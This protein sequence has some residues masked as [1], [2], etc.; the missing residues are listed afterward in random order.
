VI[1]VRHAEK[2][3]ASAMMQS[4]DMELSEEGRARAERFRDLVWKYRP[5]AVY[6]TPFKRTR[7]TAE[8]IARLRGLEIETYDPAK[9]AEL[10]EKILTGKRKRIVVVGHSNTIPELANLLARKEL[11]R[12]LA[13]AE[14]GVYYVIRL[15][16]G[17]LKR[18]EIFPF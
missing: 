8:P 1:L 3:A 9:Q 2:V 11:F 4:P 5:G 12:N 17:V 10:V 15:E 18:I 6:S 16:R 14:Y 7:Q 13:E